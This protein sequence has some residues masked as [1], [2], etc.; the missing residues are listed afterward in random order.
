MSDGKEKQKMIPQDRVDRVGWVTWAVRLWQTQ[1]TVWADEHRLY[2][3]PPND[4]I[5]CAGPGQSPDS[6]HNPQ[7]RPGT[8]EAR[9]PRRDQKA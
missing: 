5:F 9:A 6:N 2:S 8:E 3:V 7:I 1:A 4:L